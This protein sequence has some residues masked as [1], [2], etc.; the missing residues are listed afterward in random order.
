MHLLTVHGL[1]SF[2]CTS[3]VGG[4]VDAA[5]SGLVF[6]WCCNAVLRT[7]SWIVLFLSSD[8]R[9]SALSVAAIRGGCYG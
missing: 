6:S 4:R 9:L 8:L 3:P 2:T 7:L 1:L 5:G